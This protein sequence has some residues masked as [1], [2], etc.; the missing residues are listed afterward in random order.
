MKT[1]YFIG[2]VPPK[3]YLKRIEQFQ[4]KWF[5]RLGVEPHITIKAQGGLTSDKNWIEKVQNVCKDFS[6]FQLTLS[7][8]QYLGENI[9]YL[10]V[11]SD[12]IHHLHQTL[13][14]S[15]APSDDLIKQYFELDDFV[16]HLT[17]GHL[18]SQLELK[19]MET[20]A[21]TELIPY[22]AFDV[23]FIRIYQ[24]NYEKQIYEKYLDIHLA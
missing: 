18:P 7:E 17:L 14:Q 6:S 16:P 1:E 23:T 2:I 3:E 12:E 11:Q 19:H 9:L 4:G 8:P 24:T 10:S 20:C 5:D 13:V 21:K 22:P 15:I